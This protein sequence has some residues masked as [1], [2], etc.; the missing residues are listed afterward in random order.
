M[1][2][3]KNQGHLKIFRIPTLIGL[4]LLFVTQGISAQESNAKQVQ[5]SPAEFTMGDS[6]CQDA[7]GN[8]D[9][10]S[11]EVPHIVKLD[12]YFIDTHEVSNA[13][14]NLCVADLKCEPNG[15]HEFR[16]LE[17]NKSSQPVVFVKWEDAAKY[18]SWKG[19]RLPTEAEWEQVAR[20]DNMGGA[21][22]GKSYNTDS[23]QNSGLLEPNGWGLYD[24]MGNVYEWT[25]D[26]YGPYKT[27]GTQVNPTGPTEGNQKTVRGGA[28]HSPSHFLRASDRVARFPEFQYSDVGFR[29]VT[30]I[31][32]KG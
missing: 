24:M 25:A 28:W 17:F 9:W 14:Y 12:G 13:D 32:K 16:P 2:L 31:L 19:G 4:L 26:W 6:F 22:F 27:D 7:Q 1:N 10:C 5:V 21:Y 20:S 18:C 3:F 30:P 8:S 15:L 29:C 23:P 11:D